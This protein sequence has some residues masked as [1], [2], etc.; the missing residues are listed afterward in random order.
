MKMIN[1]SNKLMENLL[2]DDEYKQCIN[3]YKEESYVNK[4]MLDS[5]L[6]RYLDLY[7]IFLKINILLYRYDTKS[8]NKELK[9]YK[10][11]KGNTLY[12]DDIDIVMNYYF[13]NYPRCKKELSKIITYK[14]RPMSERKILKQIIDRQ[15]SEEFKPFPFNDES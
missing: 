11:Y 6:K 7:Y 1:P 8:L 3:T 12:V 15:P 4:D 9:D 13:N 10:H 2:N 5:L 14:L